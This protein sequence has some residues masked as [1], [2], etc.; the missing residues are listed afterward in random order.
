MEEACELATGCGDPLQ[1]QWTGRMAIPEIRLAGIDGG[2]HAAGFEKP[3]ERP[4]LVLDHQAMAG[5]AACGGHQH[6]AVGQRPRLHQ[7]EHMLEQTAI[8]TLVDR[9]ADDQGVC[10][11]DRGDQ[12]RRLR[13]QPPVL[14]GIELKARQVEYL[15][16]DVMVIGKA[17]G[18]RLHER[19]RLR[20]PLRVAAEA[21]DLWSSHRH[22]TPSR[23]ASLVWLSATREIPWAGVFGPT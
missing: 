22:R 16:L 19:A 10:G 3:E 11:L 8:G 23:S 4:K 14:Q 13:R 7:I 20:R 15:G 6:R 2:R 12:L 1:H 17:S 5:A 9:C 21:Y 18:Y